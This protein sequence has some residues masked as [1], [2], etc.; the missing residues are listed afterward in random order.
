MSRIK[1]FHPFTTIPTIILKVKMA[2][3]QKAM[4]W[5][6]ILKANEVLQKETKVILTIECL[7]LRPMFMRLPVKEM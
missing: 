3:T 4:I 2:P 6:T 1:Y 7:P 5:G